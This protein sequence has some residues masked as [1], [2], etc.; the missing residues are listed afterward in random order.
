MPLLAVAIGFRTTLKAF[1]SAAVGS[2][3]LVTCPLVLFPMNPSHLRRHVER[4][5]FSFELVDW[6]NTRFELLANRYVDAGFP[7]SD[8]EWVGKDYEA[9]SMLLKS[10]KIDLPTLNDADGKAIFA[11]LVNTENFSFA[12]NKS[13]PIASRME[14]LLS[15]M[16][17]FRNVLTRYLNE[18][19]KGAP[20]NRELA[21]L[22]GFLLRIASISVA[23]TDE[24]ILALPDD[25][26]KPIR[27]EGLAKFRASIAI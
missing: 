9:V 6:A 20:L 1:G 7:A 14:S 26:T 3:I 23:V 8:R 25:D 27:L 11:R 21:V 17:G 19:N 18:A 5:R 24:F 4:L 16:N 10:G 12:M 13:L 22:M 2:F 15:M